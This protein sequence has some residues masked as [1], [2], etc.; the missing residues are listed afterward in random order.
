MLTL[1]L[2]LQALARVANKRRLQHV[3]EPQARRPDAHVAIAGNRLWTSPGSLWCGNGQ[4]PV[5]ERG[6]DA[7]FMNYV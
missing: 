6:E 1:T 4:A 5:G 2:K 3:P 7:D